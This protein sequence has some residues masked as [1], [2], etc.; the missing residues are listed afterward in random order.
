M[1]A[2]DGLGRYGERVAMR[3]LMDDGYE[4]LECN[5]RCADGE[6][7]IIATRDEVISFIEVKTRSSDRFGE[8]AEAVGLQKQRKIRE[9]AT[10]W[11][12]ERGYV[13][14]GPSN[15]SFDVVEVRHPDKGAA[16]VTHLREAF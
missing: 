10:I 4:I 13:D 2:Q 11:L 7:D 16:K 6:I 9:L 15:L 3:R 12:R 8:P 5:W 14:S 1:Q